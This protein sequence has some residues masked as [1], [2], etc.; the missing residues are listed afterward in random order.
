[1]ARAVP[2]QTPCARHV[3]VKGSVQLVIVI[4]VLY[5]SVGKAKEIFPK[6][7]VKILILHS[8]SLFA[9]I[10]VRIHVV[11]CLHPP[12]ECLNR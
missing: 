3:H 1:M 12:N 11:T 9:N 5:K 10:F 8:P 2:H 4:D 6:T 7:F